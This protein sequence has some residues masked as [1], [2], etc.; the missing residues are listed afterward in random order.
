MR[1]D[2]PEEDDPVVHI[3]LWVQTRPQL[4][5]SLTA[6]PVAAGLD[7]AVLTPVLT[8]RT[9]LAGVAAAAVAAH[10]APLASWL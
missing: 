8:V 10:L 6:Q 2:T 3:V 4:D 7:G 9:G 5:V 1:L